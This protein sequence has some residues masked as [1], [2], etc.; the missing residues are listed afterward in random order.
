[1]AKIDFGVMLRQ[2]KIDFSKIREAAELCDQLGFH[3]IW[4]YDHILGMGAIDLDIYEAWTM[5]SALST[6]TSEVRIGTLVLCNSFRQPS[7]LAKMGSTLD[8]ISNGRLEFA[9][10]AGW[11][12]PEYRAYGYDFPDTVT[13]I[14]QL[15][16][17]VKIIKAMWTEDKTTFIGKHYQIVDAYCNP[18]PIQKP[19][20]PIIIGGG[21]ERYLLRAAAELADEWNCPGTNALEIDQK[22]AALKNHCSDIGR[23]IN[24]I[25]IS[26]QT[27]CVIAK[28][29][30]ELEE[31]IPIAKKRY[32]F[33]GEI[34]KF[35]IIGTPDQCIKKVEANAKRGIS[36]Y[37]IFF[38]DYMNPD[39]LSFFAKEVIP[40][41]STT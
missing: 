9:I 36:K 17:S 4:F 37:T 2:Q 24:S 15:S 3:S 38:S 12:E 28:D 41:F 30:K 33:F 25:K 31:K 11:F 10:G 6:V 20:P 32:G 26:Q 7:L 14:D 21:G 8:V 18:K 23:D 27:I 19:H 34:E 40:A 1:M 22:L 29:K 35:G 5:M 16:E 39:T 13:R